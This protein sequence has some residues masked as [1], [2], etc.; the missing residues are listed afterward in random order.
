MKVIVN[1]PLQ[2]TRVYEEE[3]EENSI[4]N[5]G[6]QFD[7]NYIVVNKTIKDKTCILDV[8]K[9]WLLEEKVF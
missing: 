9:K 1:I 4:P 6:D 7:D 3:I 8:Q 2:A 5:I